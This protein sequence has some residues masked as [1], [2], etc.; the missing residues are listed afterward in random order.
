MNQNLK[1]KS[2]FK[3]NGIVSLVL[4]AVPN[5]NFKTKNPEFHMI[6]RQECVS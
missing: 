2:D 1:K 5:I 6:V 4:Y 3:V